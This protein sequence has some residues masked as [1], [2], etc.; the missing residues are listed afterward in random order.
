LQRGRTGFAC[1]EHDEIWY[2]PPFLGLRGV[3]TVKVSDTCVYTAAF[4]GGKEGKPRIMQHFEMCI[5]H[6]LAEEKARVISNLFN[7]K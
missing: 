3:V 7:L 2:F 6:S 4:Q 1:L 5:H